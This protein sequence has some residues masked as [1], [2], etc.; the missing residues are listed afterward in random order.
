MLVSLLEK[1]F[2]DQCLFLSKAVKYTTGCTL[3]NG[4]I[5]LKFCTLFLAEHLGELDF[6]GLETSFCQ[7]EANALGQPLMFNVLAHVRLYTDS[8]I[9]VILT[10]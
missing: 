8:D 3:Q 9:Q 2:F 6:W 1:M 7:N 4:R 5:R 10:V